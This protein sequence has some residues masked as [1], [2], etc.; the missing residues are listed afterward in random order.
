MNCLV[1]SLEAS[2]VGYFWD[3]RW[4]HRAFIGGLADDA[5]SPLPLSS[6]PRGPPTNRKFRVRLRLVG[7]PRRHSALYALLELNSPIVIARDRAAAEVAL[8]MGSGTAPPVRRDYR[9]PT[10]FPGT[11]GPGER[12]SK[13]A[14]VAT[15]RA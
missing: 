8:L 15:G 14:C 10:V 11:A 1:R 2:R 6:P 13:R 12:R 4:L 3:L 5:T 7:A 9:A